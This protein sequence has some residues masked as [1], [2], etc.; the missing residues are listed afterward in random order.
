MD[1]MMFWFWVRI[2]ITTRDS[3]CRR[4]LFL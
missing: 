4:H 3:L 1:I 2:A